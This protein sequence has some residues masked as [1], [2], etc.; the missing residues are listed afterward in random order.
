MV[1]IKWELDGVAR[2]PPRRR[3]KECTDLLWQTVLAYE[4][5]ESK[6]ASAPSYEAG[7]KRQ[8]LRHAAIRR[9]LS[10]RPSPAVHFLSCGGVHALH[11][12][13]VPLFAQEERDAPQLGDLL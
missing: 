4:V 9:L 5:V 7:A 1:S 11:G 8:S 2:Q 10:V 6:K 3:D 12:Q 13:R